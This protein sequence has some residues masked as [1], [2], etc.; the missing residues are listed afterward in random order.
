MENISNNLNKTKIKIRNGTNDDLNGIYDCHLKCFD[1]SDLWYKS[2]IQQSI[3]NSY[4]IEKIE[5]NNIIGVL[6]QGT[7]TP[8]EESDKDT[9]LN[10]TKSGEVFK[11][12]NL[13]LENLD[14]IVMLCIDP[15]FRNKGLA[16]KLIELHFNDNKDEL[17]CLITRKSNQAYN[18]YLKMGYEH[19]ATIKDKYFFPTEDGYFMVKTN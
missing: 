4:V 12:N 14:G 3:K 7:I 16:K 18:L 2:I 10:I 1:K 9:F 13:H 5:D 6:L 8:C 19:I 11:N 17:V 15:E